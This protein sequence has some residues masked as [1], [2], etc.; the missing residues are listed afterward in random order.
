MKSPA[1]VEP[2]SRTP[3]DRPD[4]HGGWTA[5]LVL[6]AALWPTVAASLYFL[7]PFAAETPPLVRQGGYVAAKVVQFALP[8]VFFLFL[9]RPPAG[10]RAAGGARNLLPGAGFG[11]L[12]AA[13][14][15]T[16]YFAGLRSLPA[17]D[18]VAARVRLKMAQFGVVSPGQFVAL[19]VFVSAAH[20]L[21]EEVYWRWLVF[22]QLRRWA[23]LL[24]AVALSSFAFMA[25]HVLIA[26]AYLPDRVLTGVLPASLAVAGCGAV[27]AWLYERSGS[28]LPSWLSHALVDAALF[29]VGWDVMRGG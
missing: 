15:V 21:L 17:M 2:V 6:F 20:S 29:V 18:A 24:P 3:D 7:S 10:R 26:W 28:L 9:T 23:G 12:V 4:R 11:L 19:A 8:V 1:S 25:H 14:I 13:A 27:W 5:G 22:G 16:A